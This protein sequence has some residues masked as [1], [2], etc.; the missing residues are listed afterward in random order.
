MFDKRDM[1]ITCEFC[2]DLHLTLMFSGLYK[3][4]RL[5]ESDVWRKV[6]SNKI[7]ITLGIKGLPSSFLSRPAAEVH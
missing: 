4:I 6:T 1:A 2:R 5:K 7:I 3:K